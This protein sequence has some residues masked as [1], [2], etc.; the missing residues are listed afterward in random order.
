MQGNSEGSV[1]D[2]VYAWRVMS[3]NE[4]PTVDHAPLSDQS[5]MVLTKVTS[6]RLAPSSRVLNPISDMTPGARDEC[7]PEGRRGRRQRRRPGRGRVVPRYV[8]DVVASVNRPE[9][10]F[11]V[12]AR[13]HLAAGG[14]RRIG[15]E[16][17][18]SRLAFYDPTMRFVT[19]P[20]D[21]VFSLRA[22]IGDIRAE[23]TVTLVGRTVEFR[24]RDVVA[25]RVRV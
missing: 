8:R 17:H 25:T 16:V 13:L 19:E 9:S 20:G 14:R 18:P 3:P 22:S 4:I 1:W 21:Y 7:T 15:F 11:I 12:L 6:S 2:S 24:Q 10:Q 23:A 5:N